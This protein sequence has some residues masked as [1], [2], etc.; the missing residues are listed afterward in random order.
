MKIIQTL[1]FVKAVKKL[2]ASQ[3]KDL[4][5]AVRTIAADPLIGERKAGDLS[6]VFEFKFKMTKQLTLLAYSYEEGVITLTLLALGGHEN[7]YRDL[8]RH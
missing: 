7:F 2:H 8:K 1:T 6:G 4:D 5:Q 3:K